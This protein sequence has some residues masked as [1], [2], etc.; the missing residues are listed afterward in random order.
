[1]QGSTA[2]KKGTMKRKSIER[3]CREALEGWIASLPEELQKA[4]MDNAFIAGGAIASLF[5][6]EPVNDWDIYLRTPEMAQ[7]VAEHYVERMKNV[8]GLNTKMSNISV[9]AVDGRIKIKV[10]SSGIASV[11][12]GKAEYDYFESQPPARGEDYV[13]TVTAALD[14]EVNRSEITKDYSPV[15]LTSNAISLGHKT[16]DKTPVQIIL[17]FIGDPATVVK[18]FDWVHATNWFA[19]REGLVLNTDAVACIALKELRYQ[20]TQYPLAAMLRSY[21][22]VD[23]GWQRPHAGDML[24][25]TQQLVKLNW[26][27][28]ATWEDQLIGVDFAYF[29]EVLNKINVLLKEGKGM[30]EIISTYLVQIVEE[31]L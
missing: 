15:M 25:L 22:F 9:T 3:M 19:L 1:M 27:D 7:A 31:T 14:F 17:R 30:D 18:G 24:V 16:K 4:A 29:G 6:D 2:R 28:P 5:Q 12:S 21:K 13:Q 20:A 8:V 11:T 10:Q 26:S 23:R